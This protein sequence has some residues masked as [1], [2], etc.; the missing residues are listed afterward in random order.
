MFEQRSDDAAYF[1][2]ATARNWNE[3]KTFFF[4]LVLAD[5]CLSVVR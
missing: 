1:S 5:S 2:Y 4:V 3:K